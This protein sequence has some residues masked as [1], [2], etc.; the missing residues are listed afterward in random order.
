MLG[1]SRLPKPQPPYREIE[2]PDTCGAREGA[3]GGPAEQIWSGTKDH[4]PK[5]QRERQ[6]AIV[7]AA[8]SV[9][10]RSFNPKRLAKAPQSSREFAGRTAAA[11]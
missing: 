4:T 11:L 1:T 2:G 10:G 3:L 8:A 7:S 6:R 5:L 9:Q